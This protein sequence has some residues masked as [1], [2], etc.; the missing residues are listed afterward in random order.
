MFD[1]MF[2]NMCQKVL[3]HLLS[4]SRHILR[5]SKEIFGERL[6][7]TK[8]LSVKVCTL[9]KKMFACSTFFIIIENGLNLKRCSL[10]CAK[11]FKSSS[12]DSRHILKR[13]TCGYES[14]T[15]F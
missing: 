9:E 2:P 15:R 14:C 5:G 11:N 6:V 13:R 3:N 12:I 10:V 8:K 1:I 7:E 4:E